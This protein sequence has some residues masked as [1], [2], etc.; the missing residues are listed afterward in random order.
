MSD[1][2]HPAV[3]RI[4]RESDARDLRHLL[5]RQL[6]SSDLTSLLLDAMW[7]RATER[8]PSQ[9]LQQYRTDRFTRPGAV[10]A[11]QLLRLQATV[12]DAIGPGF[13]LV[14]VAPLAPLGTHTV[15]SGISQHR[16]VSTIRRTEVAAD[17]TCS[18]ALEAAC[19]R[20]DAMADDPRSATVV[21]LAA[22]HR[23]TRA[24]VVDEPRAWAHF[25][26]LGLVSAGRDTGGRRFERDA[27]SEHL[28]ALTAACRAAGAADVTVRLTDFG[29]LDDDLLDAAA[30]RLAADGIVVERWPERPTGRDYYAGVAFKVFVEDGDAMVEVGDGGFVS[31]TQALLSSRKE[32]LVIS[33]LGLERL[34]Q[35]TCSRPDRA[36]PGSP[37]RS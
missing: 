5:A 34:A 8:S 31:W 9:I 28:A 30:H 25:A 11:R 20:A 22:V 15:I 24:Q 32:R 27:L 3:Q 13:D 1:T 2:G 21:R 33:G 7:H 26:L 36:A 16:V 19:R 23:V 12:I 37:T 6:G 29:G 17:T 4:T 14:D 10:D 18:L 35:V